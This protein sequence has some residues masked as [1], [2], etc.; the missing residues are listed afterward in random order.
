MSTIAP[1]E[2]NNAESSATKPAV[3]VSYAR[4]DK[5]KVVAVITGL[6]A[7]GYD[8]W[9]DGLIEAGEAFARTIEQRL[10]AVEVVIVAWS[11]TSVNSDWV[12]DE[13]AQGRDRKRLVAVS[14]DGSE[15]P[16]G[17]RQYHSL[18]LSKWNGG[19]SNASFTSLLRAIEAAMGVEPSQP[20]AALPG[21]SFLTRRRVLITGGATGVAVAAGIGVQHIFLPG[22][23]NNS[24]AVLPFANMSGDSTQSYF[25]DGLTEEI[26]ARLASNS[27]LAVAAPTSSEKFR[28]KKDDTKTIAGSLGV[29]F[30]LEGSVRRAGDIVRVTAELVDG[31]KGFSSW[32][33][34]FDRTMK[35]IFAVQSE[36]A[37]QVA[38]ALSVRM[39]VTPSG[40]AGGTINTNAY[41]TYLRGKALYHLNTGEVT[42]RQALALFDQAIALDPNYAEPYAT[43]S[44]VLAAISGRYAAEGETKPLADQSLAAAQKAVALAPNLA[45]AQLALGYAIMT[46]QLDLRGAKPAFDRAYELGHGD[47]NILNVY[48][49]YAAVTKQEKAAN[50]AIERAQK[51]DP[52]NPRVFRAAGNI[53]Y[54]GR[55]YEGTVSKCQKAL[56][57]NPKLTTTHWLMGQAYVMLRQFDQ[58]LVHFNLENSE[59]SKLVGLAI[60]EYHLGNVSVA[61]TNYQKL[62]ATKGARILFQQGQILSQWGQL[63]DAAN[64]L[65]RAYL[66]RD[67]GLEWI[68]ADPLLDPVR[69]HPKFKALLSRMKLA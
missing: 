9:W 36:I 66:L 7:A 53:L 26:R 46:G 14:L 40:K 61:A 37:D 42:D 8:V 21:P 32:S 57:M 41:D 24:V 68:L 58:A 16:L 10:N 67:T 23:A 60:V 20:R 19:A 4:A 18:D 29:A 13:A 59:V 3:F 64:I 62:I 28:D 35:D 5:A 30:L 6:T 11:K 47:A 49:F 50:E 43:R 69:K 38:Q 65:T 25:S 63:D 48:A 15:P 17:F 51:L 54:A 22:A 1:T 34:T 39:T 44:R 2:A 45:E 55:H 56:R 33:Q 27:G 31:H 52:L 12:R